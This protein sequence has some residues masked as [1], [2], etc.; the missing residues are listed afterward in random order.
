MVK[1]KMNK[2]ERYVPGDR[3]SEML[4][5]MRSLKDKYETQNNDILS[6]VNC[7]KKNLSEPI[8]PAPDIAMIDALQDAVKRIDVIAAKR[9]KAN[10]K[11][12]KEEAVETIADSISSKA[13]GKKI[14]SA[15]VS[16][17]KAI[18]KSISGLALVLGGAAQVI[19]EVGTVAAKIKEG[20]ISVPDITLAGA[21]IVVA[22]VGSKILRKTGPASAVYDAIKDTEVLK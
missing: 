19:N 8:K 22:Y 13:Y 20:I 5:S 3:T 4:T 12:L 10:K 6:S 16:S 2:L 15:M 7:I 1:E 11:D 18:L 9:I 14:V 21:A 17:P